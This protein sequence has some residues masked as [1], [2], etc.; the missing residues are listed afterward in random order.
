MKFRQ[1]KH[2]KQPGRTRPVTSQKAN[3]AAFSYYSQRSQHIAR[4]R[5][6]TPLYAEIIPK[7][8]LRMFIVFV[9]KR[10]GLLIV[11]MAV[12]AC[13]I[14]FLRLSSDPKVESS[15]ITQANYLLHDKATYQAAAQAYLSS[16]VFNGNKLTVNTTK[17]ER[18]MMRQYPE[19]MSVNIALP[20]AGH[21]PV[22]YFR[23]AAPC[24]I[25]V[26]STGQS[27]VI[28][29]NGKALI[30]AV[31]VSNLGKLNLPAIRDE[32]GLK[33]SQGSIVLSSTSVTFIKVVLAQLKANKVP[34][35]QLSLPAAASQLNVYPAGKP[36]YVKFN[37]QTTQATQQTGTYLATA[38]KLQEQGI[39]PSQY[40]D[41]R[42]DG[43]AYYR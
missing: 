7:Q 9:R 38:E 21:R 32:S 18:E 10:F 26:G 25:L 2:E 14:N 34:I 30:A 28:D 19:L 1:K 42:V 29:E 36:Y 43:R 35:A 15:N 12:V 23:T 39:T 4:E 5:R 33:L 3:P 20:L 6:R 27:F 8:S 31:N 37:L 41:V 40:I 13:L 17:V 24:F 16:S 11:G 22:M